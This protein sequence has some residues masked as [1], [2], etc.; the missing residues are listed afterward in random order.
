M[1]FEFQMDDAPDIFLAWGVFLA[2]FIIILTAI[3]KP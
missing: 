2:A 3:M 1:K